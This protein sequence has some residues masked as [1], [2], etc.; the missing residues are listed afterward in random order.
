ML[1]PFYDY[2]GNRLVSF[3][4]QEASKGKTDRYYLYL[5]TE[6]LVTSLYTVLKGTK[7]ANNLLIGTKQDL[8]H[9]KRLH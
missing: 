4:E 8:N 3:F 7:T 6:D 1:N 9:T 2:I 5:P